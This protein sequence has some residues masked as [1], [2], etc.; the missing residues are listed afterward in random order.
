MK[1]SA[2]SAWPTARGE[3][4]ESAGIRHG[5]GVADTLTAVSAIWPTPCAVEP[6]QGPNHMRALPRSRRG[7]GNA[8]NLATTVQWMTPRTAAGGYTRDR[9]NPEAEHLTL[10]GQGAQWTTPSASDGTR[11]GTGITDGMSGSSLTQKVN[12]W[13]TPKTITGGANSGQAARSAGGPDL[14]EQIKTWPTPASRDHKGENGPDHLTNGTGR[15]HLDQLPNAVA[16]LYS[17]PDHQTEPHG[18]L[19]SPQMRVAHRVLRDVMPLP[20]S[21][22]SRPYSPPTRRNPSSPARKAWRAEASWKR[23]EAKR[24]AW[25]SKRRLSPAFVTWL[26]GWPRGHALCVCSETEFTRWQRRMRGALSRLPMASGPW[27]WMPTAEVTA[28][29]QLSLL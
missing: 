5:R 10:E 25:W 14:Q 8:P 11:G 4:A 21:T 18:P 17:R 26:M 1:D 2:G 3:D 12:Q 19:S 24:A 13:T 6:E 23:W 29:T 16:F 20:P 27:I 15:L 7:G 28:P 9:G 22:V